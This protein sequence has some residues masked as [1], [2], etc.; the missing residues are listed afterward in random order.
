[1]T[2]RT[3]ELLALSALACLMVAWTVGAAIVF[4]SHVRTGGDLQTPIV[5]GCAS[6]VILIVIA[7]FIRA[8]LRKT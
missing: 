6:L 8:M 2:T 4:H 1:M 7:H 5:V 3:K